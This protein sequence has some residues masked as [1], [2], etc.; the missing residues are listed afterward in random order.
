L[1]ATGVAFYLRATAD[2]QRDQANYNELIAEALQ[3]GTSNSTLAAQLMLA[4]YRI[5]PTQ[6]LASRL[7]NTENTPLSSS[8]ATG[9][10]AV[11]SVAFSPGGHVLASGGSDGTIRL[12]DVAPPARLRPLGRLSTGDAGTVQTVA[13]SPD[14]HTLASASDDQ[15]VR[16]WN[17]NFTQWVKFGC[18]LVQRNL[19][20]AE[21][22][23]FAPGQPYERTCPGEPSGKDAPRH[24]PAAEY[25][26]S[27]ALMLSLDRG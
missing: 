25:S 10:R 14:G 19:S 12:W 16:L 20:E 9:A 13:F 7:L 3:Y 5:Q 2:Q 24:A 26:R 15:T 18:E 8:P 23:Q 6:D 11:Y 17:L 4:A 1:A 27:P 21:W 22:E